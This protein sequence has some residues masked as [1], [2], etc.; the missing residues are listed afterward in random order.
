MICYTSGTTG[1][2]KGAVL[3]H[4]NLIL[5][6]I[7]NVVEAKI[8]NGTK[9]LLTTPIFHIAG[10]AFILINCTVAGTTVIHRD[11]N[12]AQVLETIQ[13]EKINSIFLVPAMWNF[14]TQHPDI[15]KYDLSSL[16]LSTTGAAICPLEVKKRILYYFPNT[17]LLDN[18]GQTEM[19]PTTTMLQ[20]EDS[21]RKSA[22]VGKP[23]LNVEIRVVDENMND[24]PIGEIG[25]IVYRGPT[26]MKGYYK[27][28][29]ATEEA[30][31]G[32]WFH[33]GD[34]VRLDDEG[35]VYVV[36]RKKD[37]IISGGENIYPAEVEAALYKHDAVLEVAV[38]GVPDE[39]WGES[40]KAYIVLK[41]GKTMSEDEV[42]E[43]CKQHVASY[44][45]PKYVE[46][47][48]EL[49]RNTSG[50]ILKRVLRDQSKVK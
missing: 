40:V 39:K 3:S 12:P 41:Q 32:G 20:P 45:K 26:L 30:F 7:N 13:D 43:H 1:N 47:I 14:V 18:F 36:D 37:M 8:P 6:A 9:Q 21:F 10:I 19:S 15:D 50:K 48:S 49:P 24:V 34:L 2:P 17:R 46:F 29:E 42:L 22:S 33:S 44:K 28:P 38:I 11:F 27:K 5:G 16:V 35:F 23:V 25:E 31:K 4:K